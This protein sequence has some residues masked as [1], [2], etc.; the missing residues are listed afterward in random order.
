MRKTLYTLLFAFAALSAKSQGI[1]ISPQFFG[2]NLWYTKYDGQRNNFFKIDVDQWTRLKDAKVTTMRMGGGNFNTGIEKPT[3]PLYYVDVVDDIRANGM[4]PMITV[5]LEINRTLDNDVTINN[6]I[7]E[8]AAKAAEIVRI[9]NVVNK[10]KVTYFILCNEP[11]KD[12]FL[13]DHTA[14]SSTITNEGIA[15]ITRYVKEFSVA[16]KMIDPDIKIIAPELEYNS[17]DIFYELLSDPASNPRSIKGTIPAYFNDASTGA[18][19]GKQFIDYVSLHSYSGYGEDPL[20]SRDAFMREGDDLQDSYQDFYDDYL[21]GTSIR[22]I[23]DEFNVGAEPYVDGTSTIL[24]WAVED[25]VNPNPNSFI[26][27][28]VLAEKMCGMMAGEST[29]GEPVI[30]TCNVWSTNESDGYGLLED[31]LTYT[32]LPKPTYWHYWMLS[33]YFNGTY[34]KNTNRVHTGLLEST[35]VNYGTKAFAS[36]NAN[37]IAVLVLN[38]DAVSH[39]IT[40]SF[41]TS[42][43]S[44]PT[45]NNFAFDMELGDATGSYPTTIPAKSSYLIFFD[46]SGE[47]DGYIY[48]LETTHTSW[49]NGS[50]STYNSATLPFAGTIPTLLSVSL[51]DNAGCADLGDQADATSSL[52]TGTNTWYSLPGMTSLS[53]GNTISN[54]PV[55]N[56][57]LKNVGSCGTST[58]SFSIHQKAPLVNAGPDQKFCSGAS[59]TIGDEGLPEPVVYEIDYVW[60]PAVTCTD[61]R[62]EIISPSSAATYT[63]TAIDDDGCEATDEITISNPTGSSDVFVR[64]SEE[65]IGT[66]PNTQSDLALNSMFWLSSDIW[67]RETDDDEPWHQN[68]VTGST[69]TLYVKVTNNSCDDIEDATLRVYFSKASTGLQWDLNWDDFDGSVYGCS[70]TIMFGDEIT[71]TPSTTTFPKN[72]VTVME[73][74]WSPPDPDDYICGPGTTGEL[75]HFCILAHFDASTTTPYDPLG[76]SLTTSVNWNAFQNNNVAWKNMEV[77]EAPGLKPMDK[78]TGNT[79]ITNINDS[80]N[81]IRLNFFSRKDNNEQT[82]FDYARVRLWFTKQLIQ[83]WKDGGR[84]G[85]GVIIVNDSVIQLTKPD[86]YMD[87]IFMQYMEAQAIGLQ[88]NAHDNPYGLAEDVFKFD[89]AQYYGNDTT[90]VGGERFL[91]KKSNWNLINCITASDTLDN[92]IGGTFANDTLYIPGNVTVANGDT[93]ILNNMTVLMAANAQIKVAIGGRLFI[94]HSELVPACI[95]TIWKGINVEGDTVTTQFSLTNSF[96]MGADTALLMR[97]LKNAEVSETSFIGLGYGVGIAINKNKDF[98]ISENSIDNYGIGI[99]TANGYLP[100]VSSSINK[101]VISNVTDGIIS[102]VCN[103]SKLDIQCNRL[104][105]SGYGILSSQTTMKNQ[106][107]TTYG[108]G[109]EFI[110]SSSNA[111]DMW[112]HIS[113]NSPVYYYDS[114]L[115][116][117]MSV[118]TTASGD[119][120]CYTYSF[121]TSSNHRYIPFVNNSVKPASAVVSMLDVY[122]LPNPHAGN[123]AIHFDLGEEKSGTLIITNMYGAIIDRYQLSSERS[124]IDIHYDGLADGIYLLSL[125]NSKGEK[126]TRKMVIGK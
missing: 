89:V 16:M 91:I 44:S 61:C 40:I 23:V 22:L 7:Y 14:V 111:D 110:S 52:T 105:Y 50:M 36:E 18:A 79:I 74:D 121:D 42:P 47:Y 87:N 120:E 67:N 101:N 106:G 85:D 46:C 5:P 86:A 20:D 53:T 102:S 58:T 97:K 72:S 103:H 33:N 69:N 56:Y 55:G 123:A 12:F 96:I 28:Q 112:Y 81:Y 76:G 64:D 124:Q 75:G 1:S 116:P 94:D 119:R 21:T 11:G 59:V 41:D 80:S 107:D 108:A 15:I 30:T 118:T 113:G 68:P 70:P 49:V 27:A 25:F 24:Q 51:T 9:V 122:A 34:Y 6:K 83:S 100:T 84:K 54:L 98:I 38:E 10:R 60:S 92:K 57:M 115:T 82:I 117:D 78:P 99:I 77:V 73:I 35:D 62:E 63:M 104:S 66:E 95:G 4:E 19:N 45:S 43:Q 39:D 93:L 2:G 29:T 125:I 90:P 109:N 8:Y 37:Y 31:T 13:Y 114:F 48:Y 26:A 88:I 65:D 3:D 126:I 71:Y 17:D 32:A